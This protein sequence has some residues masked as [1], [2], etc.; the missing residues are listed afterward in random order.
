MVPMMVAMSVLG[1]ALGLSQTTTMD[2][3]VD[4]VD[5]TSRGSALGL[6]LATNRVGQTFILA[7]AGA[8]S[9]V[10]GVEAAFGLL[11]AV[12]FIT[13]ASGIVSGRQSSDA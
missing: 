5:D 4:L 9:G 13:A 1:F 2:W 3:V 6:R 10:W 11:A 12:M 8:V 7:V